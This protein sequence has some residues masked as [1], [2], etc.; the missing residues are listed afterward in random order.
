M[1]LAA[2]DNTGDGRLRRRRAAITFVTPLVLA[3]SS[4]VWT[5]N[6]PTRH[7]ASCVVEY[8]REP[9]QRADNPANAEEWYRT[10]DYLL[11]SNATLSRVVKELGLDRDRAFLEARPGQRLGGAADLAV[12]KLSERITVMRIPDTRLVRVHVEDPDPKRAARVAN[13]IVEAYL[14]K[15][16]LDRIES[17]RRAADWVNEQIAATSA[18]V[19]TSDR[20]LQTYLEGQ[21][22]SGL[23]LPEQ[24]AIVAAEI[25]QLHQ[26]LTE[27]R[28]ERI[29]Q[30]A[31]LATLKPAE[32]AVDPFDV[33][34]VEVDGHEQVKRLRAEYQD[35]LLKQRELGAAQGAD[36]QAAQLA[37]VKVDALREQMRKVV[38]G[39]ITTAKSGV[40]TATAV[41]SQLR[42][43][44][45][46]SHAQA[47]RLQL[48]QLQYDRIVRTRAEGETLLK[49]LGEVSPAA[50]VS[51]SAARVVDPA[52][53]APRP[54]PA[55]LV[56][57]GL[58]WALF[59]VPLGLLLSLL[60][61]RH[62]RL[63]ISSSPEEDP[64]AR[65]GAASLGEE[66]RRDSEQPHEA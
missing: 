32:Q 27:A 23:P 8:G 38:D 11:A 53:A 21:Q 60:A 18:R 59:G 61:G 1:D 30:E 6:Q 43:A 20:E 65:D 48:Q 42:A 22:Q 16:R 5:I 36:G 2:A 7:L 58:L 57:N 62:K 13:A 14:E 54:V 28:V 51:L 17:A 49:A 25:K 31:R 10:Q 41:E 44:L 26:L 64:R 47:R 33:H 3:A 40:S 63:R 34:T 66:P 9:N 15:S 39:I 4:M 12:T 46:Q 45:Q 35:V 55:P 37:Q 29:T 50:E 56:R 19:A 52:T 24:Q